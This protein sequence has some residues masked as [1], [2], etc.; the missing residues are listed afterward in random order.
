MTEEYVD[1]RLA[2]K[3]NGPLAKRVQSNTDALKKI[4]LNFWPMSKDK[5][6]FPGPQP[7]SLERRDLPRLLSSS[8]VACVKSDGM[9][10]FLLV[11]NGISYMIDRAFKFY[12]VQQSFRPEYLKP[13]HTTVLFD[14]E[15]VKNIHSQWQYIV[16]DCICVNGYDISS[17][18]FTERYHEAELV[19]DNMYL[20]NDNVVTL[21]FPIV[22]KQFFPLKR[23]DLISKLIQEHKVDHHIDGIIFTPVDKRIGTGTQY[24]LFK[25]K[26]RHLHTF[27]FKIVT[28]Q[29][30]LP[31]KGED[32][33]EFIKQHGRPPGRVAAYVNSGGIHDLYATIPPGDFAE[34][35]FFDKLREHCPTFTNNNIVECEYDATDDMFIPIKVR[36]DKTHPNSVFTVKKTKNNILENIT[37]EEL[38]DLSKKCK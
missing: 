36:N 1:V 37:I 33:N 12:V 8:Y 29:D 18:T 2:D 28:Y 19:I 7:V 27:D 14:G 15:L 10:F 32:M 5:Q 30:S 20:I 25:W 23:L 4:V 16:H 13:D 22:T 38:L 34:T 11:H 9:R 21:S 3:T 6:Y 31:Y 35:I 26:P 24:D 17:K